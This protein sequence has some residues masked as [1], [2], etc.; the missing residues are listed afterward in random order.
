ME[1]FI[2]IEKCFT[3]IRQLFDEES[4]EVF[5]HCDYEKLSMFQ[6]G[7]GTYIR[8]EVISETGLLSSLLMSGISRRDL[9]LA[10]IQ[11]FYIYSHCVLEEK[12]M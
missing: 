12:K 7:I 9:S 11:L 5:I 10:L 3:E 4:F 8:N 1:L 6:F 2:N